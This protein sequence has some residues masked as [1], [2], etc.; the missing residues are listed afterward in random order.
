[1][2]GGYKF[3]PVF[4]FFHVFWLIV[5]MPQP[6]LS[7]LLL[8]YF[9]FTLSSELLSSSLCCCFLQH[10][11]KSDMRGKKMRKNGVGKN[12]I[13]KKFWASFM[14][15]AHGMIN[16]WK[17]WTREAAKKKWSFFLHCIYIQRRLLFLFIL[18]K[19]LYK[20]GFLFSNNTTFTFNWL[21][22]KVHFNL[23]P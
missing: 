11:R 9:D 20:N 7:V 15:K 6:L 17:L 13:N 2:L 5:A 21:N 3:I 4:K 16:E 14:Y 19:I 1:M 10:S 23:N 12:I 18:C 22:L 8:F